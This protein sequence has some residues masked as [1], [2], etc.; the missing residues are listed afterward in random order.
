MSQKWKVNSTCSAARTYTTTAAWSFQPQVAEWQP[1]WKGNVVEK[2]TPAVTRHIGFE[3]KPFWLAAWFRLSDPLGGYHISMFGEWV[4]SRMT[5]IYNNDHCCIKSVN[6]SASHLKE[7]HVYYA[8]IKLCTS[9]GPTC[10]SITF[11]N[12][13][14]TTLPGIL[15]EYAMLSKGLGD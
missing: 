1:T 5:A 11:S 10:Q 8:R 13:V 3:Q 15:G 7:S 6:L 14:G 4:P 12:Y 2:Q 9:D